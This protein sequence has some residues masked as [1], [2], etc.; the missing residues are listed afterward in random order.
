L[1]AAPLALR[2]TKAALRAPRT[3]HPAFDN[4]AQAILF[5]TEDKR[6]RMTAFLTRT[7]TPEP[8]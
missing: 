7:A 2:L 8:S 3:A 6:A 1:R 5:D 4:L